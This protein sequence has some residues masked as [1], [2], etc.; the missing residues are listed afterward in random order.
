MLQMR[1]EI[2]PALIADLQGALVEALFM[3][4]QEL[5]QEPEDRQT[6]HLYL[7]LLF[8]EIAEAKDTLLVVHLHGETAVVVAQEDQAQVVLEVM[9]MVE[10][11]FL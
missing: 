10:P 2:V 9:A 3:A 5:I 7:A 4:G 8:T 1:V 11:V 6:K